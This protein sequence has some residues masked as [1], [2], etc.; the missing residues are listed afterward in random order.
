MSNA[1]IVTHN[2]DSFDLPMIENKLKEA[3]YGLHNVKKID[4]LKMARKLQHESNSLGNLCKI[5]GIT[6]GGNDGS[7]SHRGLEDAYATLDLLYC[8]IQT[9]KITISL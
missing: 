1:I 3:G 5:Y 4:T 8:F 7:K 9:K 2:G 6:Y